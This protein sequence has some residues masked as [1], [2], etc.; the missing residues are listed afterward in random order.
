M[1]K[2]FILI[3]TLLLTFNSF[4]QYKIDK[5][6]RIYNWQQKISFNSIG[7]NDYDLGTRSY[8]TYSNSII[9]IN[10]DEEGTGTLITYIYGQKKYYHITK[11][12][13]ERGSFEFELIDKDDITP[14][15]KTVYTIGAALIVSNNTIQAFKIFKKGKNEAY[16]LM[17]Q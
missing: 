15:A 16:I 6:N 1:K 11:C 10:V 2:Y 12:I 17:N 14:N 7:E 8:L 3:L 4:S 5:N 13:R 9:S